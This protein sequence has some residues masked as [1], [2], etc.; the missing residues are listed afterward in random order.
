MRI[1]ISRLHHREQLLQSIAG[2]LQYLKREYGQKVA[3]NSALLFFVEQFSVRLQF[4]GAPGRM[5]KFTRPIP[6]GQ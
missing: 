5:L 2:M 3:L 4:R 1:V 6:A